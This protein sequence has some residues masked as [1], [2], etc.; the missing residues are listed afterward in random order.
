MPINDRLD[1]E[2]V[3][4]Y[5]MEYYA[6][7]ENDEFMSFVGTWMNLE[8]IILSK[9]TQEQKTKHH[10]FSLIDF[11]LS[12]PSKQETF[13]QPDGVSLV[14]QAGEQWR[15]LSSLQP[16]PPAFRLF[17]CLSLPRFRH[18]GQA[19]LKLLT[20]GDSPSS[21]S[22]S[23]GITGVS[24][25]ARPI[26][27]LLP[28]LECDSTISAHCN[29]RFVSSSDSPASASQAKTGFCHDDQSGLKLL[30]SSDSVTSAPPNVG[31][32]GMSPCA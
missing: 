30:T 18:V 8:T 11:A 9:L 13:R 24:H 7:I 22:Q 17:S 12:L 6:A 3:A 32:T 5:T 14:T 27:A 26:V 23:F 29:V 4:H 10:M 1:R 31:I 19:G 25:H 16:L 15:D 21:A 2:N 20:S 28:K